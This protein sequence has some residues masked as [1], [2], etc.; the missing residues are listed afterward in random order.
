MCIASHHVH[1]GASTK[2]ER[3]YMA[4]VSDSMQRGYDE[5]AD[6][7]TCVAGVLSLWARWYSTPFR[8]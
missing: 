4:G 5:N 8:E 3:L 6:T 1:S 7:L 2:Y